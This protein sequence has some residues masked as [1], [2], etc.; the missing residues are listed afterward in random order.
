MPIINNIVK[1]LMD[2]VV[3]TMTSIAAV[4]FVKN[5]RKDHEIAELQ[6]EQFNEEIKAIDAHVNSESIDQLASD[7]NAEYLAGK[8]DKKE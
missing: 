5:L 2:A 4:L 7:D 1:Y 6:K 3:L 8:T